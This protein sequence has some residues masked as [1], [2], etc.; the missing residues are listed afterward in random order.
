MRHAFALC[1]CD[2]ELGEP[3][4][5]SGDRPRRSHVL[6]L[7]VDVYPPV[8]RDVLRLMQGSG[9][10]ADLCSGQRRN[11]AAQFNAIHV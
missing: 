2:Q 5:A 8:A 7:E 10:D 3:H 11:E 4:F 1:L 6:A 9:V